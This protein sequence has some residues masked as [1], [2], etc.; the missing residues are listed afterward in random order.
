MTRVDELKRLIEALERC[1]ESGEPLRLSENWTEL[2]R[3][4]LYADLEEVGQF[5]SPGGADLFNIVI[6]HNDG[7]EGE[8]IVARTSNIVI[9]K[10]MFDEAVK[11]YPDLTISLRQGDDTIHE[12][13]SWLTSG[14]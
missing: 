7:A 1:V 6:A 13:R 9:G 14:H 8:T 11:L 10:A 2:L 3:A 4:A 5:E 12:R